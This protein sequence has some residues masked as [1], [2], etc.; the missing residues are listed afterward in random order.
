MSET[1]IKTQEELAL[2]IVEFAPD[3]DM[4]ALVKAHRALFPEATIKLN[5]NGDA[6]VTWKE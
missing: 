4:D 5:R 1:S 3:A 2:A 6:V